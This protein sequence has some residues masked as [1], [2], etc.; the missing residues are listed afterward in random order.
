[1]YKDKAW[2]KLV[3]NCRNCVSAS[4][5]PGLLLR[6][7]NL[8]NLVATKKLGLQDVEHRQLVRE[9][10]TAAAALNFVCRPLELCQ[11]IV[12]CAYEEYTEIVQELATDHNAHFCPRWLLPQD[13]KQLLPLQVSAAHSD[14]TEIADTDSL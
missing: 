1:M 8:K 9:F 5:L 6:A 14:D 13:P 3:D 10:I 2:R 4:Q 11:E 7:K 12:L